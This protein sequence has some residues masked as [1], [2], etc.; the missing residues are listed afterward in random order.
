MAADVVLWADGGPKARA[1]RRPIVG[2]AA[3]VQLLA[4]GL[5]KMPPGTHSTVEQLN[6]GP[7][8]VVWDGERLVVTFEFEVDNGLV[9][10]IRIAGNPDK[11]RYL[12]RRLGPPGS[13]PVGW[14]P[15]A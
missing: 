6:G 12:Q 7:T 2:V 5:R 9:A 3:V 4:S 15:I 11:L 10:G 1:A 14:M 8:L 13:A